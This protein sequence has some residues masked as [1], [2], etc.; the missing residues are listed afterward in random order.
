[1]I[2]WKRGAGL[3]LAVVIAFSLM[4]AGMTV[5]VFA[6]TEGT[7]PE[8]HSLIHVDTLPTSM[9]QLP[10]REAALGH[11]GEDYGIGG[12][13]ITGDGKV[14]YYELSEGGAIKVTPL[15][16]GIRYMVQIR[17]HEKDTRYGTYYVRDYHAIPGDYTALTKDGAFV[18][19]QYV[20]DQE[21][22]SL[23]DEREFALPLKLRLSLLSSLS[24]DSSLASSA[25]SAT[26]SSVAGCVAVS[27]ASAGASSLASVSAAGVSSASELPDASSL[28]SGVSAFVSGALASS[29]GASCFSAAAGAGSSCTTTLS[30]L[31]SSASVNTDD[32]MYVTTIAA[33]RTNARNFF[34][35]RLSIFFTFLFANLAINSHFFC[36]SYE[37][38]RLQKI[39]KKPAIFNT[40]VL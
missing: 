34:R 28:T 11:Y 29:F 36:G 24:S 2:K 7:D 23:K 13:Y 25:S 33:Q 26:T 14:P 19:G 5:S 8:T 32:G 30:S 9:D 22:I 39:L 20:D 1:M 31:V 18:Y 4:M 15:R 12:S 37:L 27:A 21:Q 17:E 6:E 10:I 40:S 3:A 35:I 16:D 38:V